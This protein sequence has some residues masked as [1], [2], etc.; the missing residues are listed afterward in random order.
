MNNKK[1]P[2]NVALGVLIGVIAAT[3]LGGKLLLSAPEKGIISTASHITETKT[4]SL[5]ADTLL[6]IQAINNSGCQQSVQLN[7]RQLLA[8][9][10][11]QFVT[12]H[13][14]SE[15]PESFSGPLLED[16]LDMACD[17]TKKIKL[18]ALNNYAID[19]DFSQLKQY[20]PIIALSVNGK[21]LS[22]REKGPLWIMLPL[23]DLKGI[24]E[25]SLDGVLIWQLSD[26]AILKAD[27]KGS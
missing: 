25:K 4:I 1:K 20:Q 2:L 9:P 22:I 17:N 18:T 24:K 14:W 27:D 3:L 13:S 7:D 11:Q 16:V 26:I 8:L 21:R 12:H 5:K 10:Q 15:T 23:D 6:N 19:M